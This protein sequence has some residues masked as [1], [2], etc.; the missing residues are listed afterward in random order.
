MRKLLYRHILLTSFLLV[1]PVSGAFPQTSDFSKEDFVFEQLKV[2]VTFTSDGTGQEDRAGRIKIQSN[3]AIKT[4]G[5]LSFPYNSA[6][7]RLEIREISVKKTDGTVIKTA[8]SDAQ[9]VAREAT[10]LAPSYTDIPK[11]IHLPERYI[12]WSRILVS[13]SDFTTAA[14]YAEKAISAVAKVRIDTPASDQKDPKWQE[15]IKDL[16]AS[17]QSNLA[18]TKQML[19]WQQQQIRSHVIRRPQ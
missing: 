16:E 10:R 8:E 14:Q 7:E 1:W 12:D 18:W 6:F 13:Q 9:D 5:V 4:F 17:A 3:T 15:W 11:S 19:A 2:D